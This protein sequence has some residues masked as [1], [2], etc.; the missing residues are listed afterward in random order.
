M[1]IIE[2]V[3]PKEFLRKSN[4]KDSRALIHPEVDREQE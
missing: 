3:H 2:S 1:K 4:L